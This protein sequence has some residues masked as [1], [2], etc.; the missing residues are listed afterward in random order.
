MIRVTIEVD[1]AGHDFKIERTNEYFSTSETASVTV[2]RLIGEARASM[3]AAL[4]A[5]PK[6]PF[7]VEITS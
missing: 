2:D 5:K 7:W 1:Q 3:N 4:N 6:T